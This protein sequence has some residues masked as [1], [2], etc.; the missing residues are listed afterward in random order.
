VLRCGVQDEFG[1]SGKPLEV[2][3]HFGLTAE[4]LAEKARYGLKLKEK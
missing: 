3:E 4:A 2:L 1:R